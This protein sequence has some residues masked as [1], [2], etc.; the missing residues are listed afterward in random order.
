[1]FA[2]VRFPPI[3]CTNGQSFPVI[4][5]TRIADLMHPYFETTPRRTTQKYFR[6][7]FFC[8][9]FDKK[10]AETYKLLKHAYGKSAVSHVVGEKIKGGPGKGG[11]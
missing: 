8:T 9:K 6:T 1:M 3:Q 10:G 5:C 2:L 4:G 11:R 7:T